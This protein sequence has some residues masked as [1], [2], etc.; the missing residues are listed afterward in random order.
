LITC[1][2]F[3]YIG[4]APQRFIVTAREEPASQ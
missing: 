2:P 4:A 1:Y 3:H